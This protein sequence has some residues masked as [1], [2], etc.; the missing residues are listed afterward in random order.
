LINVIYSS[1]KHISKVIINNSSLNQ[2]QYE[3]GSEEEKSKEVEEAKEEIKKV[4]KVI[5][6]KHQHKNK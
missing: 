2:I 6:G 1:N 4:P 5:K 3:S